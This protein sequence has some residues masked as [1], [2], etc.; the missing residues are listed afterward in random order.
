M[1]RTS[2]GGMSPVSPL[3]SCHDRI[4]CGRVRSPLMMGRRTANNFQSLLLEHPLKK[5]HSNNDNKGPKEQKT[6]KVACAVMLQA[7]RCAWSG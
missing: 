1:W 7:R 5:S 6:Q 4:F 3:L 2:K